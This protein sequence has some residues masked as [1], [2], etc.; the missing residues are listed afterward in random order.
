MTDVQG[1]PM[2]PGTEVQYLAG[3]ALLDG[4][5]VQ[6]ADGRA[7]V[8]TGAGTGAASGEKVT[9]QVG[10]VVDLL[11]A[12]GATFEAGERVWWDGTNLEVV[13]QGDA[14]ADFYLGVTVAA[15]ASGP[16]VVGVALN[17]SAQRRYR[18]T[19]DLASNATITTKEHS[20]TVTGLALGDVVV[21]APAAATL[22]NL[23]QGYAR[24]SADNTLILQTINPTAGALDQGAIAYDIV[25]I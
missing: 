12:T 14:D 15:K 18:Q 19:I 25:V 5:V 20:I 16:T 11:T 22:A 17:A 1:R 7:G 10:G 24:V 6:V 4:E 13:A 2:Y 23:G 21:V 8:I 9:A 3:G